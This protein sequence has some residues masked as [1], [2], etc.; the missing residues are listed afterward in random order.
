MKDFDDFD[1]IDL[2]PNWPLVRRFW[3]EYARSALPLLL[4]AGVFMV[5]EGSS[6]GALSY[7]VRPMF[8]QLFV[9]GN[10]G[11]VYLIAFAVGGIFIARGL[12]GFFQRIVMER[13]ARNVTIRMEGDLFRH[14]LQM[15]N[16]FFGRNSPGELMNKIQGDSG[17]SVGIIAATF[18]AIGRDVVSVI[19][20]LT[21]ALITDWVW[22]LVAIAAAPLLGLPVK[23]LQS[24]IRRI[25]HV[26][27]E[28]SGK[29]I[30]TLDESLHGIETIKLNALETR[31]SGRFRGLITKLANIQ[32]RATAA[33]AAVPAL[34]D[35]VA[36]VGFILVLI[37]G[38]QQIVA[39]EKTVGE[40]MSF[41]TAIALL[42]EPVRRLGG[43]ATAWQGAM[44]SLER[45]YGI[46]DTKSTIVAPAQPKAMPSN[47]K[48]ADITF[49]GVSFA[50]GDAQ[51]LDNISF[52]AKAGQTTALVG[53]SGSGKTTL[54]KLVSRLIDPSN[55]TVSL[56]GTDIRNFEL[57]ELRGAFSVVTQDTLLFDDT[58]RAN[59]VLDRDVSQAQLQTALDAAHVTDFLSRLEDGLE[60][61]VGTR[62]S[63]LSGGQ[64]QRVAISRALLR[65]TPF[66]MLDEATSALDTRS[67]KIVQAALES[68]SE[69]RTTMVI[70]H[71]LSTI[72]DADKIVVMDGGRV[73]DEGT[74]E[75]LLARGGHYAQLYELQFKSADELS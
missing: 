3:R 21:V 27:R 41:F 58:L 5:I 12:S 25:T 29:V 42:F 36:A 62:G 72:Q 60:T 39:G 54:F 45:V 69:G 38:G 43:L 23:F 8:N 20:L 49:D 17:G 44:V 26:A 6:L 35:A 14:V 67:E 71:R 70:A 2:K 24:Y 61:E 10:G 68:L 47:L 65:D 56:G 74:H 13:M 59:V 19:S 1:E 15:D 18:S 53:A 16:S 52:T 63:S 55:G 34:M 9:E 46:F 57:A 66:L 31:E 7:M 37:V 4:L 33:S 32:V 11:S 64:R 51:V 28:M 50:Y 30:T 73:L 40:F 48:E 75:E 22:T